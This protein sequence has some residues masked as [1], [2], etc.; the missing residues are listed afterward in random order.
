MNREANGTLNSFSPKYRTKLKLVKRKAREIFDFSALRQI[1]D[2]IKTARANARAVLM[3][4]QM[5]LEPIR[6]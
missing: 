1:T 3:V 5:G 4:R 6:R 2:K